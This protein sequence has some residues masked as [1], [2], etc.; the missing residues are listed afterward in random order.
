LVGQ[1]AI[2]HLNAIALELQQWRPAIG[3]LVKADSL[4]GHQQPP[5]RKGRSSA[6]GD[7]DPAAAEEIVQ[8]GKTLAKHREIGQ[9]QVGFPAT[10]RLLQDD[11]GVGSG[12]QTWSIR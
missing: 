2:G 11:L 1:Q 10:A 6:S 12:W 7:E 4:I 3:P 5:M 9:V 8:I